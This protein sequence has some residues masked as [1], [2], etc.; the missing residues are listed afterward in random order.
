M[1][2]STTFA[3]ATIAALGL[4]ARPPAAFQLAAAPSEAVSALI[5]GAVLLL[6]AGAVKRKPS[7]GA[8]R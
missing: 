8:E 4:A 6:L 1:V 2:K 3:L 7:P 5:T